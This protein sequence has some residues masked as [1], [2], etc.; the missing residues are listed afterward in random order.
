MLGMIRKEIV[1]LVIELMSHHY[2][3][4]QFVYMEKLSVEIEK[5]VK[6][7]NY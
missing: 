4:F 5:H 3:V 1:A 7:M 2:E 6:L